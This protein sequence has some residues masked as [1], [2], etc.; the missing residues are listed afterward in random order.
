MLSLA[1]V[2][3][4]FS[5]MSTARAS[6]VDMGK[7]WLMALLTNSRPLLTGQI[8]AHA[9]AGPLVVRTLDQ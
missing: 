9:R 6:K 8:Q 7:R 2:W 4:V 5:A 3:N 1:S